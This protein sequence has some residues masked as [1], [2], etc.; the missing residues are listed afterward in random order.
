VSDASKAVIPGASI[1]ATNSET[2]AKYETISTETGNYTLGQLPAG[3]YQLSVELPGFKKYV[4]QGITVQVAQTLRIDASLEVGVATDEVTVNADA[5]LLRTESS[6]V[7]HNVTANVLNDLPILGIGGT[8]SGSAGI[9]NPYAM[10]EMVPGTAWIPNSTV[11][12]NGAPANSQSFRLEGQEASNT[13]TPGV[14][15]QNQPSVDAIQEVSIQTSNFAPEYGQVGGGL[16][17]VTMKSGTNQFHGTAYDY[18]VNEVFNAGNPLVTGDPKGNPRPR[19]RRNDYGFTLGGPVDVPGVYDGHNRTF[20]FFNIEQY[21]ENTTVNNLYQTVPTAAYRT[22]DFSSAL[23]G[24]PINCTLASTPVDLCGPAVTVNVNS[25]GIIDPNGKATTYRTDPLGNLMMEGMIYDPASTQMVKGVPVRTAFKNN[26]IR[27][28]QWDPVATKIQGLFPATSG[29]FA[30]ALVSNYLNPDV[31]GTRITTIPSIKLDQTIGTR[32]KLTFYWQ[33]TR[34]SNPNGNPIF[35]AADG[36]PDPITTLLGT[37]DTASVYRLNYDHTLS[38]RMVL[39]LGAGYRDNFFLVPSVTTKGEIPN[40]D[41]EVQL[42]LHGGITHQF[43]P[44]MS[45]FLS[46][47]GTGGMRGIGGASYANAITQSP[48]F[49]TNLSLVKNSHSYKVGS[50][51]RTEGYPPDG[52]SNTSGSYT[53]AA[54]STGQ[55][56]QTTATTGSNTGFGYASFLLGQ[57]KTV[58]ISNP[59]RPRLG[60]KQFGIYVQDSWKVT[61]KLTIDYGLRYD[62]STYLR[63][64]YGRAPEFSPTTPNPAPG[65]GGILGATIFDGS[66][67]GRC[68][69]DIAHN[70]PYAFGP[71]FALAYQGLPKTVFRVGIGIVYGGTATNNNAAGTLAGST[72]TTSSPLGFGYAVTTLQQGIPVSDKPRPFPSYDADLYP[73]SSPTPGPGPTFMDPNSGRPARQIQWSIG[74]QR[75]LS[76]NLVVEATYIGNRGVWWQAPGLRNLN[77]ITPERLNSFG[78]DITNSGDRAL[79]TSPMS[80]STVAARFKLPYPAFPTNQLLAQALRPF[81]QFTTIPVYWDPMGRTWYDALQL[82]ATKRLSHGL[83]VLSTFAWSKALTIGSEVGEPNPGTTGGALVNNVFNRYQNKYLSQFDQPLLFN[84]SLTYTTPKLRVNKILSSA[85]GEWTYGAFLQYASGMPM[86]VPLANSNLNSYLFQGQSFANRKPGVPLLTVKDLNCHCY[87]PN[88]TFVLNKDAWVDPDPGAFGVSPAYYNDYRHQRRPIENINIGRTFQLTEKAKFDIRMEFTNIFNRTLW[89]DPGGTTL[90]QSLT[91]ATLPQ[92]RQPLKPGQTI[93][94]T[95][96]GFGMV[97]TTGFTGTQNFYPRQ[98][99]VVGRLTF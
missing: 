20:F 21:R 71:R 13:G 87:D 6:E 66:G 33:R 4:R 95:A 9:R 88:A 83:Q 36:L 69:C 7:S 29:P 76:T 99:V 98:G 53:F 22:G 16:F 34:T 58:S 60:K 30:N 51:F 72:A 59:T 38:P 15:A 1:V 8:Q 39:H 25:L 61:R 57:V 43:F 40:Y 26:F 96:S 52:R 11:R 68:N 85:F 19:A 45:G 24:K 28:D 12:V 31:Q 18:F 50:E 55:P 35:G 67:P 91:N 5:P 74:V 14:Q 86:Q 70:Y 62:Y 79:L 82:K 64:Q 42:G 2:G 97:T 94:N 27:S 63:E 41:A 77:A 84:A 90:G 17:N 3:V 81:P 78:L 46:T 47:N 93:G 44:P 49:N 23:T 92:T 54:D 65:L 56:F 80:N 75:E 10:I 73:T 89:S 37:F 32:G 48:S